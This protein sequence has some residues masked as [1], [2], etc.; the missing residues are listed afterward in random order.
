MDVPYSEPVDHFGFY[1]A[2]DQQDESHERNHPESCE[3]PSVG[4][5]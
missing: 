4:I 3:T 5:W 1:L 2:W